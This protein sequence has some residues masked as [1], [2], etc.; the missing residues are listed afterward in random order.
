MYEITI[1]NKVCNHYSS[2]GDLTNH[3]G[4][5]F[6]LIAYGMDTY[7]SGYNSVFLFSGKLIDCTSNDMEY[8]ILRFE[9]LDLSHHFTLTEDAHIEEL[10]FMDG[11]HDISKATNMY[12]NYINRIKKGTIEE[13]EDRIKTLR[14]IIIMIQTQISNINTREPLFFYDSETSTI[15]NQN[16]HSS[17]LY[18]RIMKELKRSTEI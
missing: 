17:P 10:I 3:Y 1:R 4:K 14:S 16:K 18:A 9:S 12:E 8:F 13:Y 2:I 11:H 7:Y 15:Y 6:Y 5:I